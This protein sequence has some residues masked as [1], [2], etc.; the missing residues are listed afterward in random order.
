MMNAEIVA[1]RP[2]IASKLA[3]DVATLHEDDA[4]NNVNADIGRRT[5]AGIGVHPGGGANA[6]RRY[7]AKGDE[8]VPGAHQRW[9]GPGPEAPL[10][11]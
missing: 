6:V 3:K 4:L 2:E 8:R 11:A 9:V 5:L 10:T 1:G 7:Q